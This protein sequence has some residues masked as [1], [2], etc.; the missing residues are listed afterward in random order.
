MEGPAVLV[1]GPA[2]SASLGNLI[3]MEILRSFPKP[4]ESETL[5]VGSSNLC[6]TSLHWLAFQ[7]NLLRRGLRI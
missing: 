3:E 6:L 5:R 1:P 4:A 7:N 2:A